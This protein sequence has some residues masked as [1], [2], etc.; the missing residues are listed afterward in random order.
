MGYV[1]GPGPV[2]ETYLAWCVMAAF[3]VI[4][5]FILERILGVYSPK[6]RRNKEGES[7]KRDIGYLTLDAEVKGEARY[8]D[9]A[10]EE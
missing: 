8:E 9:K 7:D 10:A 2:W 6:S 4:Y 1:V 3:M 5:F